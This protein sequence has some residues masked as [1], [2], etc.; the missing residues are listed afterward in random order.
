MILTGRDRGLKNELIVAY[1][2]D[3][4]L[5]PYWAFGSLHFRGIGIHSI[6]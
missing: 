6:K 2:E 3:W 1:S 5:I 4:L